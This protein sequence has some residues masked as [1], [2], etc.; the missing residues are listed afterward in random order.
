MAWS[1]TKIVGH[2]RALEKR[3]RKE[4][5][6]KEGEFAEDEEEEYEG[7]PEDDIREQGKMQEVETCEA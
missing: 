6:S 3:P 5:K 7:D 1:P 2:K 4:E